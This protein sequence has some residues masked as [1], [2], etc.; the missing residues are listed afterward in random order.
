MNFLDDLEIHRDNRELS[1]KEFYKSL[2]GRAFTWYAKLRPRTI[3]TWKNWPPSFI[4]KFLEEEGALHIID[5]EQ[6]KR[7]KEADGLFDICALE[8]R[9]KKRNFSPTKNV[10]YDANEL[11]EILLNMPQICQLVEEWLKE[12]TLRI[13]IVKSLLTK[14]Q[15][16]NPAFCVLHKTN[17]HYHGLLDRGGGEMHRRPLPN[18]GVN[19][20]TT[21]TGRIRFKEVKYEVEKEVLTTG[22]AK[23]RGFRVL[24]G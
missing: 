23:T 4:G 20:I 8:E 21:S 22:L 14:E 10:A 16:D 7:S 13:K 12:G 9:E 19:M 2:S 18:H 24:F 5:L 11:L 17:S 1:L 3:K 15:Y 6:G